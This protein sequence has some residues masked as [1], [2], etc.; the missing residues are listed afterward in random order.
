MKNQQHSVAVIGLGSMGMGAAKSCIRAGLTTYGVDINPAALETL[1][2]SGAHAVSNNCLD[3][4]D[5][6][7]TVL[8]LVVNSSQVNKVLF[9]SKLAD[10]LRPGT[11]VMV[12]ATISADDAKK[13]A[14]EGFLQPSE[15]KRAAP[16]PRIMTRNGA[17]C[18]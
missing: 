17:S 3:F 12:S 10:R 14:D 8:V 4:A 15:A 18:S 13:I 7:D 1:K 2:A 11:A 9:D 5:K 16:P 6:L